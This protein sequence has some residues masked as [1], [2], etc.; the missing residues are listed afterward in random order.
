MSDLGPM[1]EA[2]GAPLKPDHIL[3]DEARAGDRSAFAELW[4]RHSQ[5]GLRLAR[6]ITQQFDADDLVSEAYLK[7]L[8]AVMNGGG[9]TG[10]FRPYLFVTI[11]NI[12]VSWSRK[13]RE[14]NLDA[15]EAVPDPRATDAP[16]LAALDADLT[17]RAFRSLPDRWQEVLWFTEVDALA[18]A[19][20]A[21]RLGLSANSVAALSYRAREGLRQAWIQIHIDS[22]GAGTEH[23]WTL[24][25][26][27]K[28]ARGGLSPRKQA[29]FDTHLAGCPACTVIAAEA[30][31]TSNR[32]T[33]VLLPL[34]VGVTGT[35]GLGWAASMGES[36]TTDGPDARADIA[37]RARP[38]VKTIR[39]RRA[40]AVAVAATLVM[41]V[42]GV[43]AWAARSSDRS[44][45]AVVTPT[46]TPSHALDNGATSP[47]PRRERASQMPEPA[48]ISPSAP[49][50]SA[51]AP[52]VAPLGDGV[53]PDPADGRSAA[54]A[55]SEGGGNGPQNSESVTIPVAINSVD[56]GGGAFY[57]IVTGTASPGVM[58]RLSGQSGVL[59]SVVADA[60]GRWRSGSLA[61]PAGT[62]QI[63]ATANG[64]TAV[65]SLTLRQPIVSTSFRGTTISVGV[66]GSAQTVYVATYDNVRI[67]RAAAAANGAATITGSVDMTRGTHSVVVRADNGTRVGPSTI[68]TVAL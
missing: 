32:F 34:A 19:E 45:V 51:H 66:S 14:D 39:H 65:T 12:A 18:P 35:A 42:G 16:I 2:T 38:G 56:V 11:R 61:V 46:E 47:K 25:Q 59:A 13:R 54:A 48:P 9:P 6:T 68:V 22:A 53:P 27:G 20:V 5:A 62:S 28:N 57:P 1:G 17:L 63:T 29:K 50:A 4:S 24:E 37:S 36:G 40:V 8:S 3:V 60:Q 55:P 67:G 23:A 10:P 52:T 21:G 58:V 33:S 15:A 7:V 49:T 26:V 43:G 64:T 30:V 41:I 31:D 44:T